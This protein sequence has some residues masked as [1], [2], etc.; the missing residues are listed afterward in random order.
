MFHPWP[1]SLA[2]AALALLLAA[3]GGGSGTSATG[4]GNDDPSSTAPAVEK[5]A[6]RAE[7]K[8]FLDQSTFGATEP[9][10]DR[11]MAVG[12]GPW[13]D[14]Q[15]AKP[16]SAHRIAWDAADAA[17]KARDAT[18][19]AGTR[20]V[21]DSFYTRAVTGD[22]Q[23]RQRVAYALSQIFVVSMAQDNV[24]NEPRGVAGWLDMLG[25]EGLTTYRALI[26]QVARHPSMGL[27]LSHLRNQKEDPARGR[28]PDENF[29]REVMQLFSIG[30]HQLNADGTPVLEAG[31]PRAS[32]THDDIAGL[33]KVF[34]GF[35]WAG[36]DTAD[37]RFWGSS[38]HRDAD[39]S[40][41]PM[42]GYAKFHSTSEKRF[43]GT[44]VPVQAT[45]DPD[46][47]LRVALDTL[48]AHPNVGPFIGRQLIQRL[49]TSHPSPAYVER[50]ARVFANNGAGQ[51]GDMKAVVRAVLLDREAR[52]ASTDP[53]AG[54]LREPVLRLTAVLRA[55]GA[56]SDSGAWL[57]GAT[58][59]PGSALGQSPLRSPSVFNFYRPGYLAPGSESGA[60]GRTAPELQL[61]HETTVAG[62][63]NYLRSGLS[64]GFGQNGVDWTASR[65]DVQ[66]AL[67][68]EI[69][70]ADRPAEL[71]DHVAARLL[72]GSRTDGWRAEALAAV[73]SITLPALKPDLSNQTQHDNARRNRARLAVFLGAV[74]PEFLL[75]K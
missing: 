63:A 55:F 6:T 35:S 48:A 22:D 17:I 41:R 49:V 14:E 46:A 13:I 62:V 39:R 18:R 24:G 29:A 72:G 9:D 43:L 7:A 38:S 10:I 34:T 64:S 1:R 47:S 57:I 2:A 60:Q 59:D 12:Y 45:A 30:L 66:L 73:E 27:Y 37:A 19:S 61:T 26:E 58:D 56:T 69:A 4:G 3:C 5:P 71:V 8:R 31:Q 53:G 42:Q 36:P 20:E 75:Q 51:R 15:F 40:W 11:V 52:D 74:A 23:L 44:V 25:N 32:Y 28:V 67:T 16:P 33:A 70:L 54:K 65:R 68:T 50:V 21:L